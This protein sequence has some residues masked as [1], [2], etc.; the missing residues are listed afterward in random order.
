MGLGLERMNGGCVLV[1]EMR[2][3]GWMG[4]V[5]LCMEREEN[6]CVFCVRFVTCAF[7]ALACLVVCA[8]LRYSKEDLLAL[9]KPSKIIPR[10]AGLEEIVS[11]EPLEPIS[12]GPFPTEQFSRIWNEG[13]AIR[14]RGRG[15][16]GRGG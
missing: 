14:G 1:G 16:G 15:R 8:V 4:G 3:L 7:G 5:W 9:R 2:V 11:H 12:H 10:M 6:S 13:G